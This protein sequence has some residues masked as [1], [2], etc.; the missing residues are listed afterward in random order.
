SD[1]GHCHDV[2]MIQRGGGS[3]FTHEALARFIG[4]D[5]VG[6]NLD[7]NFAMQVQ[8]SSAVDD[9]HPAASDLAVEAIALPQYRVRSEANRGRLGSLETKRFLNFFAHFG[10]HSTRVV[11]G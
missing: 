7:C 1:G 2:G 8:I 10:E 11:E 4:R 9:P 3:G 6:E 5:F